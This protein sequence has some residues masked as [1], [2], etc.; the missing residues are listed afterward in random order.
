VNELKSFDS[1]QELLEQSKIGLSGY[2]G[3]SQAR[4]EHGQQLKSAEGE[5]RFYRNRRLGISQKSL[6]SNPDLALISKFSFL[7]E[8]KPF[9]LQ[10]RHLQL[11]TIRGDLDCAL[12]SMGD[13]NLRLHGD[14]HPNTLNQLFRKMVGRHLE[15]V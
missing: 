2:L 13:F 11:T 3:L 1:I 6:S 12:T 8:R 14:V 4:I 5:M 9:P 7:P 10:L 15:I